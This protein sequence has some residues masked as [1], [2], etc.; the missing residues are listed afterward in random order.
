[1]T[2]VAGNFGVL[3]LLKTPR[4]PGTAL[5]IDRLLAIL[6]FLAV[7]AWGPHGPRWSDRR[8]FLAIGG[9]ARKFLSI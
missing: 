8:F 1:M 2:E 3:V 4:A 5:R 6:T 7:F 9:S